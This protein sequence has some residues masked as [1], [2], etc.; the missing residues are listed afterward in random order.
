MKYLLLFL[1]VL[2]PLAVA[3]TVIINADNWQQIYSGAHFAQATEQDFHFL[4]STKHANLLPNVLDTS[5]NITVLEGDKPFMLNYADFL[6]DQGYTVREL[7]SANNLDLAQELSV[8]SY[9]IVSDENPS[10][11]I[12]VGPYAAATDSFVLFADQDNIDQVASLLTENDDVLIYGT[13]DR[14]VR[15]TLAQ[16]ETINEG[17]R[18]SNNIK[19]TERFLQEKP[20][21]QALFTNGLFLE[22]EVMTGSQGQYPV[23]FIGRDRVPPQILSYVQQDQ[24]E[25][26]ILVGNQ[27]TRTA[28]TLKDE[29]DIRVFIKFAQSGYTREGPFQ[30]V[31]GLDT[32]ALPVPTTRLTIENMSYNPASENL[33]VLY[34]NTGSVAIYGTSTITLKQGDTTADTMQDDNS[35]FITQGE[36]KTVTYATSLTPPFDNLIAE[37]FTTYGEEINALE[38]ALE[39]SF[40]VYRQEVQDTCNVSATGVV[41]KDNTQRFHVTLANSQSTTC[42]ADV[43]IIN[44]TV[45][46]EPERIPFEGSVQLAP[47]EEA[48]IKIKQRLDA[49]DIADNE[50]VQLLTYSGEVNDRLLNIQQQTFAF[51]TVSTNYTPYVIVAIV[52]LLGIIWYITKKR[53]KS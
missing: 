44:F 29:A 38:Q 22:K 14:D 4:V 12:A 15:E 33:E 41:Y 28:K 35:F 27:L 19:I 16:Y 9:I 30:E 42:F 26:A 1:L 52:V 2:M 24:F 8:S 25:T 17:D 48:T 36:E 53:R 34:E 47:S 23:L 43:E 51:S 37:I 40:P 46:D 21:S 18:F 39:G 20:A 6:E 45:N 7:P 5:E 13:V 11:A 31:K 3:D 10:N 50:N 32:Y 49:V